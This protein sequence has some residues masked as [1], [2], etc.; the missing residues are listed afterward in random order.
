MATS[1]DAIHRI[2]DTADNIRTTMTD[3]QFA[4]STTTDA[5]RNIVPGTV[6][7]R[8][9]NSFYTTPISTKIDA[10]TGVAT[11]QDATFNTVYS[12]GATSDDRY[13][14]TAPNGFYINGETIE[15]STVA[16]LSPAS[17][18]QAL[19]NDG[20]RVFYAD[21]TTGEVTITA[22]TYTFPAGSF[23]FVG[24]MV[25]SGCINIA[26]GAT[27]V[28]SSSSAP[29][30]ISFGGKVCINGT[31]TFNGWVKFVTFESLE[32]GS[33]SSILTDT[34]AYAESLFTSS[35]TLT[36]PNLIY[37]YLNESTGTA[38][39]TQEDWKTPLREDTVYDINYVHT[40]NNF[41]DGYKTQLD[42]IALGSVSSVN[43][44]T[45]DVVLD[46]TDVGLDNTDNTSD[47]DKPISDDTQDALDLKLDATAKAVDSDKLDN[48]NSAQFLRSDVDDTL[49]GLISASDGLPLIQLNSGKAY[50]G[51]SSRDDLTI[52]STNAPIWRTG[53]T[54]YTIWTQ[55]N[56]G[57]GS[58]LDADML[59]GQH[60]S[61]YLSTTGK[62]ADSNGLD[63]LNSTEF[64]KSHI[65]STLTAA[66]LG[67]DGHRLLK[68]YGNTCA[69]GEPDLANVALGS[70]N[71]PVWTS[72]TGANYTIWTAGNDGSDSGLDADK[73][74]GQ[75]GSYYLAKTGKAADSN[76]LDGVE[77][78]GITLDRVTDNGDTTTNA[79]STGKHTITGATNNS[80]VIP[81]GTWISN[82][83]GDGSAE[84]YIT[85]DANPGVP[86]NG[87]VVTLG[88]DYVNIKAGVGGN[89]QSFSSTN[90]NLYG[91]SGGTNESYLNLSDGQGYMRYTDSS[92]N[93]SAISLNG[94]SA[95][96]SAG[97]STL[98]VGDSIITNN[99][100]AKFT[101][102]ATTT[103]T[104]AQVRAN[105][106]NFTS[107]ES[108]DV[109]ESPFTP[110]L[111]IGGSSTGI[112]YS[113]QEG[114]YVEGVDGFVDLW[115]RISLTSMGGN[116][117]DVEIQLPITPA[118]SGLQVGVLGVNDTQADSVLKTSTLLRLY[119]GNSR[120][121]ETDIGDS[122]S[123][124]LTI[125]YK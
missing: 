100:P 103:L 36:A 26:N 14:I 73:L 30:T 89:S 6:L 20:K 99:A 69:I 22:G 19:I 72:G 13:D 4:I 124:L 15:K 46:K 102:D 76:K 84:L 112:T 108:L 10:S 120:A 70:Y 59:D 48:L 45:G 33:N 66:I 119:K 75:H 87:S 104:P 41:T 91:G 35:H 28:Q 77:L 34:S 3:P 50:L 78:N 11:A 23:Y 116:T 31:S 111:Q 118:S 5:T 94:T 114:A 62:A 21:A 65:N 123:F 60:G 43:T 71:A 58:T 17:D 16:M 32:L 86:G 83:S 117:G 57:V 54:D 42:N 64:L 27:F 24:G 68:Q 85:N 93:T 49:N 107:V 67:P 97:S 106:N 7:H 37:Q 109:L 12:I 29:H 122:G 115:A 38:D 74:D 113:I 80:L 18:L 56:D 51:S 55:G 92:S 8:L 47:A 125:R 2:I 1:N 82:A 90:V 88:N 63:G 98:S 39:G 110:I 52:A 53:T 79:I 61:Y 81:D 96:I 105:P 121:Q 9:N 40:D 44:R 95:S 101:D 25:S